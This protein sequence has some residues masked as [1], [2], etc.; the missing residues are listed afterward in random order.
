MPCTVKLPG[1]KDQAMECQRR[2]ERSYS[3]QAA[4]FF[5][6]EV[7]R[8]TTLR[9]TGSTPFDDPKLSKQ[10]SKHS[11]SNES[12][13]RPHGY[14]A[15]LHPCSRRF[16]NDRLEHRAG[17]SGG[18]TDGTSGDG[19]SASPHAQPSPSLGMLVGEGQPLVALGTSRLRLALVLLRHN[20]LY[21][22]IL[23]SLRQ[24]ASRRTRPNCT[25][26]PHGSRR[27]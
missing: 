16:F 3:A 17:R 19:S 4:L 10:G 2:A 1:F 8:C 22:L 13:Q 24:Q 6:R 15:W 20:G 25:P 14:A 27:R 23:R 12:A 18:D 9:F 7:A 21:P 5:A 26:G 11:A